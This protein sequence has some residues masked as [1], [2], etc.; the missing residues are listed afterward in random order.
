MFSSIVIFVVLSLLGCVSCISPKFHFSPVTA[1]RSESINEK[2]SAL[3][4]A[5]VLPGPTVVTGTFSLGVMNAI[6]LYSNIMLF[7]FALSWFPQLVNQFPILRPVFTVTE[8]YLRIFRSQIPPVA[9]FDISAIPAL[10]CLNI[11]SQTAAAVGAEEPVHLREASER[12]K[13]EAKA[14][15]SRV[16][17]T[18]TAF[19][20]K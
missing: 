15:N 16:V 11:L 6:E 8:P 14:K 5:A 17:H 19:M 20:R 2:K 12:L 3:I 13:A 1:L 4:T 10:F 9:G 18:I 7:R